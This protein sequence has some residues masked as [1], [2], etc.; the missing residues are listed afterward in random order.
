MI[1]LLRNENTYKD[2]IILYEPFDKLK[3]EC[4]YLMKFILL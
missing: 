2:V 1:N 4:G 3:M